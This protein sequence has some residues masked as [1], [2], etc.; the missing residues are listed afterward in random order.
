[1]G[2]SVLLARELP[3]PG[4]HPHPAGEEERSPNP[5]RLGRG[6]GRGCLENWAG[7]WQ[8]GG[9]IFLA[10]LSGVRRVSGQAREGEWNTLQC[11]RFLVP[12]HSAPR[13]GLWLREYFFSEPATEIITPL[14]MW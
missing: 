9:L 6:W 3:W 7:L 4:S 5:G 10:H 14:K 12:G 8:G 1:M 11:Q 13:G 2:V